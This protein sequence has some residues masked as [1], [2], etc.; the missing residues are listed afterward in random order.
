M[1]RSRYAFETQTE[2]L[3]YA[4]KMAKENPYL[5]IHVKEP[6]RNLFAS[7]PEWHVYVSSDNTIGGNYASH[8]LPDYGRNYNVEETRRLFQ[9]IEAMKLRYNDDRPA[10]D[11][12]Q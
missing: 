10:A 7:R 11:A 12:P 1:S 3:Q 9:E 8:G 4:L 6:L 5:G 2:A